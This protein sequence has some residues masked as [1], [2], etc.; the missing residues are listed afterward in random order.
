ML[1]GIVLA[2]CGYLAGAAPA[3]AAVEAILSDERHAVFAPD[4]DELLGEMLGKGESIQECQ[5]AG[6]VAD[7]W[8][9]RVTYSC[10]AGNVALEIVARDISSHLAMVIDHFVIR[11]LSGSPP[12]GFTSVLS[13]RIRARERE[14]SW[15][16]VGKS[17]GASWCTRIVIVVGLLA[18]AALV[19]API[20][21][22]L[23]RWMI[24]TTLLL[25]GTV[26]GVFLLEIAIR[27]T[28]TER[29][30]ISPALYFQHSDL[31]VHRVSGDPF[32]HYELAPNTELPI[33]RSHDRT[34]GVSIDALGARRPA[35]PRIKPAGTFRI[36]CFGGSTMYGGSVD[37]DE[38]I[39]ARLEVHLNHQSGDLA[40][41]TSFEVWNFGTSAYTLGQAAHLAQARFAELDPD[42]I[43]VQ[44]HNVGR[45]PF[46]ATPDLRVDGD[47]DDLRHL[48]V[49]FY[50]EQF[51]VPEWIP[52]DRHVELLTYSKL[53]RVWIAVVTLVQQRPHWL[54]SRCDEL[55][56]A[57]ARGL[58]I[59]GEAKGVPVLFVAIPMDGGYSASYIFDGLSPERF[60]DLFKP[61]REPA[62]YEVHPP[63]Y[64]LDEYA[65]E[66]ARTLK[67]RGLLPSQ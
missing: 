15:N 65:A 2:L 46:L 23:L 47:P 14:L 66:L 8:T 48:D 7:G 9:I 25:A 54:C 43:V 29:E 28:D 60:I 33:G 56:T 45:R 64:V 39:P 32:L 53:Y 21:S 38:T 62:Y 4:Q 50:L 19:S 63:A 20:R 18:V 61:G 55:S 41:G 12:D 36:L 26:A 27:V 31:P 1:A 49:D 10:P 5:F 44:H 22:V 67:A 34:Y 42:M 51:A 37:D 13:S 6:G 30:L 17:R 59:E 58:S 3:Y 11:V 40:E 16:W 35:H 57:K 24:A 52:V